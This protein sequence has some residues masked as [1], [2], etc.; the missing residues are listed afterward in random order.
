MY[1]GVSNVAGG[2]LPFDFLVLLNRS[3][4]GDPSAWA[5]LLD[6]LTQQMAAGRTD[7]GLYTF[8]K[9]GPAC[10]AAT[11]PPDVD[12][13]VFPDNQ[14][15]VA[16]AI[17]AIVSGGEGMPTAAAIDVGAAHLR[18]LRAD[19]PKF[20]L[21][22]TDRPPTCARESATSSGPRNPAQAQADAVAAITRAAAGKIATIVLAPSTTAAGN[23]AALDALAEAGGYPRSMGTHRFHDETTLAELFVPPGSRAACSRCATCRRRGRYPR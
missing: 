15:A 11:V 2:W 6:T 3:P 9:L 14:Q 21:L 1:C 20:L 18:T 8:P 12:L 22:V 10:A 19:E 16:A 23:A 7:W 13:P 17:E 5:R 4:S